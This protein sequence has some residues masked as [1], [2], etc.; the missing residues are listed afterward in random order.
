MQFSFDYIAV[1]QLCIMLVTSKWTETNESNLVVLSVKTKL[2][3]YKTYQTS[4]AC[5]YT[6]Y[7]DLRYNF[8][9]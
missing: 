6:H 5:K 7:Q 8:M 1:M 3:N 4:S 2:N 9:Y